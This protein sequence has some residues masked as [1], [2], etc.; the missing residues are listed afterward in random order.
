MAI[1]HKFNVAVDTLHDFEKF[2]G[3]KKVDL[4]KTNPIGVDRFGNKYYAVSK[5]N[6]VAFFLETP[7]DT[8]VVHCRR[9][10]LRDRQLVDMVKAFQSFYGFAPNGQIKITFF[11][12]KQIKGNQWLK[13]TDLWKT[14]N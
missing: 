13:R 8:Y 10:F 14:E 7:Y 9:I 2:W 11:D 1:V 5:Q 6:T 4:L 3:V 12:D